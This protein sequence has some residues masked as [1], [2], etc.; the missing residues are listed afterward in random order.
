M[1]AFAACALQ[2]TPA[3]IPVIRAAAPGF[4]VTVPTR[5]ARRSGSS[6]M[7][8]SR[9]S[10]SESPRGRRCGSRTGRW[11]RASAPDVVLTRHEST[12][13]TP[14]LQGTGATVEVRASRLAFSGAGQDDVGALARCHRPV[15]DPQR[16]P[17]AIPRR[18]GEGCIELDPL[19]LADRVGSGDANPG[20]AA[21]ITG[22]RAGVACSAQQRKRS[23]LR[24]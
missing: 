1:I 14:R 8:T 20:A 7:P 16:R 6:S 15:R 2:A 23:S 5:S 9:R 17:L 19:R 12:P 21:R 24:I 22:I 3:R 10:F 11:H 4:R 13:A 18:S